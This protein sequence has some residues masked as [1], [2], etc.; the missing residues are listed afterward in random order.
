MTLVCFLT[1]FHKATLMH[2]IPTRF[3]QIP[4]WL[5]HTTTGNS[6]TYK[7]T[8]CSD[9]AT[10]DF[11][12]LQQNC[13]LVLL[14]PPFTPP[15]PPPS[16]FEDLTSMSHPRPEIDPNDFKHFTVK[17]NGINLRMASVSPSL[18]DSPPPILDSSFSPLLSPLQTTLKRDL[19]AV[20]SCSVMAGLMSALQL[21]TFPLGHLLFTQHPNLSLHVE[22]SSGLAGDTRSS[23]WPAQDTG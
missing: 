9:H 20:L 22:C 2:P 16:F 12:L 23:P 21:S 15:P 5:D 1:I 6:K 17:V 7:S 18:T 10:L 4:P 11:D 13:F 19:A 14:L 3:H 8:A